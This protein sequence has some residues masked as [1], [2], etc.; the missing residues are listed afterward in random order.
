MLGMLVAALPS[1]SIA[2]PVNVDAK[3]RQNGEQACGADARRLCR[4]LIEQGDGPVLNCL[5]TNQKKLSKACH[6]MLS[7]N[8]Q[9]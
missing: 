2:Q 4:K 7:D 6:K 3:S 8:G 5:Q 1:L 9:L